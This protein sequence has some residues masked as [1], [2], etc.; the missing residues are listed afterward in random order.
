M[1]SPRLANSAVV[2][3]RADDHKPRLETVSLAMPQTGERGYAEPST[4]IDCERSLA[5]F[6]AEHGVDRCHS[7]ERRQRFLPA[8]PHV[9]SRSHRKEKVALDDRRS[10]GD[11]KFNELHRAASAM[12]QYRLAVRGSNVLHPVR[13][14][15]EHR[16]QI[17]RTPITDDDQGYSNPLSAPTPTDFEDR[18]NRENT[19][20]RT[21]GKALMDRLGLGTRLATRIERS[22]LLGPIHNSSLVTSFRLTFDRE[23]R[24][25]GGGIPRLLPVCA[26]QRSRAPTIPF[27]SV[28]S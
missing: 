13:L 11:R 1:G 28:P 3:P 14:L 15:S 17:P 20:K 7:L 10:I 21:G 25:V 16:D 12:D 8:H 6:D 23:G 19:R 24:L 9:G 4:V 27:S 18:S 5:V 26:K 2:K 22:H